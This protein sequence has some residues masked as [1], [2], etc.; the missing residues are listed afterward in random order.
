MLFG[1]LTVPA[2]AGYAQ[3][4]FGTYGPILGYSYKNQ[5]DMFTNATVAEADTGVYV[6]SGGNAPTGYMGAQARLYLSNGSLCRQS[7][8][9]YNTSA[10]SGILASI[11]TPCGNG[12]YYSYGGS[13]AYNG[14]GYSGYYTFKSPNQP[15][16]G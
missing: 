8:F 9:E 7:V 15:F 1:G 6:T 11:Q 10:S 12:T 5:A 14:S 16:P 4:I 13:Q 2:S 3:S